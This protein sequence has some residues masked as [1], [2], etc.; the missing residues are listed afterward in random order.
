VPETV[1]TGLRPRFARLTPGR[2]LGRRL[3]GRAVR[4]TGCGGGLAPLSSGSQ[5]NGV[6]THGRETAAAAAGGFGM[7]GSGSI[8]VA[9]LFRIVFTAPM[10][11]L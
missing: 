4:G 7:V 3:D 6:I 8:G 11:P 9:F 1:L 5:N 10:L 2:E